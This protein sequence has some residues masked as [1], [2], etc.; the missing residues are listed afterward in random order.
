MRQDN[1]EPVLA[2]LGFV[3]DTGAKPINYPSEAGGREEL[4]VGAEDRRDVPVHNARLE[5]PAC[6]I[7][8]HGFTL[9]RQAEPQIDLY[10]DDV[11]D[12]IYKPAVAALLQE[13]MQARRVYV[14]DHTRRTDDQNLR[15]ERRIRGPASLVHNDYTPSSGIQRLRDFLPDE[16]SRPDV[17]RIQIINVW[18]SISGPVER[19]PLALCDARTVAPEDPIVTERRA[20]DRIGEI[21]RFSYSPAHK[22]YYYPLLAPEEAILIRTFDSASDNPMQVAPHCAFDDPTTPDSAA[23]RCTIE[24]RAFVLH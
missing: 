11:V 4:D 2:N 21:Y 5:S 22:W 16:L 13:R 24:L 14:F 17:G 10:D 7:D 3:V 9:I 19:S 6:D 18:R 23:P 8:R 12:A 1:P 15:D 20:R